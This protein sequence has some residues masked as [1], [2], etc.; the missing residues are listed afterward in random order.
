MIYPA[1]V[2]QAFILI[3]CLLMAEVVIVE[4]VKILNND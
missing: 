2:L 1:S 3:G 4:S